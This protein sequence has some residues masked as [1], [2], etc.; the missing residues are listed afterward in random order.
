M[1]HAPTTFFDPSKSQVIATSGRLP[2]LDGSNLY[3]VRPSSLRL[4]LTAE[5]SAKA[6]WNAAGTAVTISHG[7]AFRPIVQ[8]HDA[9]GRLLV[10]DV[11]IPDEN[12]AILDFGEPPEFEEGAPWIVSLV[13]GGEYGAE[14]ARGEGGLTPSQAAEAAAQR[15]EAAVAQ[16]QDY[17]DLANRLSAALAAYDGETTQF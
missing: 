5:N 4:E 12:T 7:L 16:L 2:S 8:V 15:A 14:A 1:R 6:T 11:T 13:Y 10:P 3:N 9:A 17:I